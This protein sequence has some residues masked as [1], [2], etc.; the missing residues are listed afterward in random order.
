MV[1]TDMTTYTPFST[2]KQLQL[3][4][5][6]SMRVASL[7]EFA[8]LRLQLSGTRC[9]LK[10]LATLFAAE[11]LVAKGFFTKTLPSIQS[12]AMTILKHGVPS[13]QVHDVG[14]PGLTKLS[15]SE[16]ASWLAHMVL[17]T[18]S[19]P[20]LHFPTVDFIKLLEGT[21]GRHHAKIRCTMEYFD[22]VAHGAPSGFFEIERVVVSPRTSEAWAQDLSPLSDVI[23][24]HTGSIED[25]HL[26]LQTDFANAFLGGGTLDSGC[27][28][29]EIRFALA[30]EHITAMMVSP[31]MLGNE[32][33]IMRGAERFSA[34][35]G[36]GKT[37]EYTGSFHD[38]SPRLADGS[39]DIT[40]VAID[41][42]DF[43][44][45][46]PET[47]FLEGVM[48]REINKARAGWQRDARNL[49][50]ATGN[51][52]C[53]AFLGDPPLKAILQ[54]LA[55]STEGRSM[56]YYSFGEPRLGDLESFVARAR[57]QG[58][59]VGGIWS[60]LCQCAG[61]KSPETLY[62]RVVST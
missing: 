35:K 27:V 12:H 50:V 38:P 60:R 8:R 37:F 11:P 18:L 61:I 25:A 55:A 23:V 20:G 51:W 30:P 26:H 40:F 13:L 1:Q 22:R 33:V 29:E 6:L 54:W 56:R 43:R 4:A 46:D 59:T 48:L 53:G 47:Q 2:A 34:S 52:G 31:R 14:K 19:P 45:G 58:L 44:R 16:V 57:T 49:S 5:L 9:D 36:Y 10:G 21:Q 41:A 15:R 42:V 7:D 24:D 28:Q 17:G 39:P 32:A 62:D 3:R